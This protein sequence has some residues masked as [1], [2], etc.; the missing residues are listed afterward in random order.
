MITFS[1]RTI[2]PLLLGLM[3]LSGTA[4]AGYGQRW[5]D[6]SFDDFASGTLD[7]AGQNIYVSRDGKV[8]TINRF[9]F[10]DDVHLDLIFNCT[11]NTYQMLPATLGTLTPNGLV[12]SQEIAVEGS[13]HL[14]LGD[15]NADGY[16]DAVFCPDRIGVHHGRRFLSIAW[17][18]A[19]G[20]PAHRVNGVLPMNA[21]VDVEIA[22]LNHDGWPDIAVLGA[23][24]WRAD[25]PS[26]RIIRIYFGSQDGFSVIDYQDLAVAGA[27][28]I[29]AADFDKDG[30]RD[31]AVLGNDGKITMIGA[32]EFDGTKLTFRRTEISLPGK[33]ALCLTASDAVADPENRP[34]FVLGTS[35]ETVY[36]V[37]AKVG[38]KWGQAHIISG[39]AASH[40]AVGDLDGD[41]HPDLALTK[42]SAAR[43][44]G[45]EQA[46]FGKEAETSC[47]SCEAPPAAFIGNLQSV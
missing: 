2:S 47:T 37:A 30:A 25:Q 19:D 7:A 29:S 44:A 14:T 21:A 1:Q 32:T 38:R 18:G 39:F 20:W 42:F 11:H 15:L 24:R 43:A 8:R 27:L 33:H 31:L 10:N 34:D 12:H 13:Q 40:M 3:F 16:T 6:D 41:G 17:G 9:D 4:P 45:G 23:G 26:E 28:D 36:L 5:V 22:D 46:G 35:Q